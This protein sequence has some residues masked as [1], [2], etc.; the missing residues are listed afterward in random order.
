MLVVKAGS[1][2][3]LS[4]GSLAPGVQQSPAALHNQA[5]LFVPVPHPKAN[6]ALHFI[7]LSGCPM[8]KVTK[9]GAGR[10]ASGLAG[11]AA[12]PRVSLIAAPERR[13]PP[14]R[15]T[16]GNGQQPFCPHSALTCSPSRAALQSW[17][18][19]LANI[20]KGQGGGATAPS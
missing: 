16:P 2:A 15:Y 9:D 1:R 8:D 3:L 20:M 6:T 11:R 7:D 10:G 12:L 4:T 13:R 17:K 19:L 14:S 18:K 5:L